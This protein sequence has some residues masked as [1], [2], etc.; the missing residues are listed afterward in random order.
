MWRPTL[1]AE[2][3]GSSAAFSESAGGSAYADPT[4][5]IDDPAFADYTIVGVP[6]G[7]AAAATPEPATWAMLLIGFA[8]LGYTGYQARRRKAK[9]LKSGCSL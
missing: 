8:G 7:P 3:A 9:R 1:T 5:T 2:F 6:A 4:F